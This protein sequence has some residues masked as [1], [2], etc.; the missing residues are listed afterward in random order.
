MSEFG[1]FDA[2]EI[3][4]SVGFSGDPIPAGKYK[5]QLVK[6][7]WK[8]NKAGTGRYCE[9]VFEILAGDQKGRRIWS[10]LNLENPSSQAVSMAR[11]EL[12]AI[13][14]AVGVMQPKAPQQLFNIPLVIGVKVVP[15]KDKAGEYSNAIDEYLSTETASKAKQQQQPVAAVAESDSPF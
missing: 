12:S 9:F 15:R 4:P 13:C 6:S 8:A 7:E 11:A 14:H 1:N 10:R 3:E 5:A 2:R